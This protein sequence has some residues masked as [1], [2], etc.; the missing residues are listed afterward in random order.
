[1]K[2]SGEPQRDTAIH[3][4]VPILPQ[5]PPNPPPHWVEFI[6]WYYRS[7]LVI[8]FKYNHCVPLDL[9]LP[10]YPSPILQTLHPPLSTVSSFSKLGGAYALYGQHDNSKDCQIQ[11]SPDPWQTLLNSGVT[12]S[13]WSFQQWNSLKDAVT[14]ATANTGK[15]NEIYHHPWLKHKKMSLT[16]GFKLQ[17]N[18]RLTSDSSGF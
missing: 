9:T 14:T 6:V 1:M 11:S 17:S 12:L 5:P 4:Q 2:V 13:H 18:I 15:W 7:F 3:I 10:N 16:Q 8:H